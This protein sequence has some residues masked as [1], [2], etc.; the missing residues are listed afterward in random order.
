M[1]NGTNLVGIWP[2]VLFFFFFFLQ[3]I[4]MP[5]PATQ[6]CLPCTL[7]EKCEDDGGWCQPM[8]SSSSSFKYRFDF[9][10]LEQLLPEIRRKQANMFNPRRNIWPASKIFY[11]VFTVLFSF[12]MMQL[13]WTKMV[14]LF[15]KH[16]LEAGI[17]SPLNDDMFV[18]FI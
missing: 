7:I 17:T 6:R 8:S 1:N 11:Y 13:F 4:R 2:P 18:G 14:K 12:N 9:F 15:L 16:P 5:I 10:V 3:R